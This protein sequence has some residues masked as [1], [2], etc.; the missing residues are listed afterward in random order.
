MKKLKIDWSVI[1]EITGVG[2]ATSGLFLIF[3]PVSFIALGL[4]LVYITEKE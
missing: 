1:T 2:L 3:P 4:F